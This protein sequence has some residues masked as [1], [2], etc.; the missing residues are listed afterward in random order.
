MAGSNDFT[1]QNIQ[2][3]YQRVLQIS[4]SGELADGTG[5][6]V[7]LLD[8]T[9]SF[10]ISSSIEIL[11]EVSSSNAD[12]ASY[13]QAANIEQPFHHI[14]ASGNISAS[15]ITGN[16]VL[17]GDLTIGDD[18]TFGIHKLSTHASGIFRLISGSTS[19]L[20][21]QGTHV[22]ASGD[23][24]SSGKVIGGGLYVTQAGAIHNEQFLGTRIAFNMGQ[25]I[26]NTGATSTPTE[27]FRLTNGVGAVFNEPGNAGY[28]FRIESN[29]N[30]HAFFVDAGTEKIGIKTSTP[31]ADF[32]V[33]GDI[34]GSGQ[35]RAISGSF[36][37]L[38][39]HDTT[40]TGLEVSGFVSATSVTASII[41]SS[42]TIISTGDISTDGSITAVSTGSFGYVTAA[43]ISSSGAMLADHYI[44]NDNVT[45][46]LSH[47]FIVTPP[48]GVQPNISNT[49][50]FLGGNVRID[51]QEAQAAAGL[52][53][54]GGSAGDSL[55]VQGDISSDTSVTTPG[56]IFSNNSS[57]IALKLRDSDKVIQLG[58]AAQPGAYF[59]TGFE[60][61]T[62]GSSASPFIGVRFGGLGNIESDSHISASGDI[63]ASG[64]VY[65]TGFYTPSARFGEA[66]TNNA[67][68]Q[69][70]NGGELDSIQFKAA[71]I[72]TSDIN[73]T[74]NITAS[75]NISASRKVIAGG[76]ISS[77]S[78]LVVNTNNEGIQFMAS[79][80]TLFK[81]IA[82][83][84][85]DDFLVQNLKNGENLR[86]R[87]G[88]SG[89]KGKVLVQQGGTSTSIV[90]FGPTDSVN[91]IG[92]VTASGNVSSSGNFL[93]D[94]DI[95]ATGQIHGEAGETDFV[96]QTATVGASQGGDIV[97]WGGGSTTAGKIYYYN[98]SG[99][100]AET[101]ADAASTSTG[102]LAVALGSSPSDGMLLR[103]IVVLNT[104]SNGSNT[105]GAIVYLD[106]AVTGAGSRTA[107]SGASDI[108]RI[109]GYQISNATTLI[110]FN[111]DN[112]FVEI[113]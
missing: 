3:T 7:P 46:G 33:E 73:S 10:A 84:T 21:A 89:N 66:S 14:T 5:S 72:D 38:T 49:N 12:T 101:D 1:G 108:V 80:G 96:V 105:H 22:T 62:T 102:L 31:V 98:S 6:L 85:V 70:S 68:I 94:G 34:T 32:H 56:I 111:P 8:V 44:Y 15:S 113:S 17:G 23:I 104:I 103:G 39:G 109:I 90:E 55:S 64:N 41:S 107:P 87:A 54:H 35:V 79:N 20:S 40:T 100:W 67:Y 93:T 11:K 48:S 75:L 50:I 60:F 19:I 86:L 78:G 26:F 27:A 45:A 37:I 63:S 58:G 4:S 28:D 57:R 106:T 76:T 53:Q 91:I 42:G 13:I 92:H 71:R 69:K 16:H 36:P 52:S 65:G 88:Q 9:A 61:V 77:D 83:N 95:N 59:Q 99:D 25:L 81:N 51:S 29:T 47:R 18:F 74:G 2:D 97:K 82:T 43:E 110:W 24:S 30:T 112:T